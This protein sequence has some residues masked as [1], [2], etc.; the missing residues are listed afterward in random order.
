MKINKYFGIKIKYIYM[1]IIEFVISIIFKKNRKNI[2]N[3]KK[4]KKNLI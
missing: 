4:K 1:R 3:S 2:I